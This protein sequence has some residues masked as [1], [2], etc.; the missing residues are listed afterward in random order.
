MKSPAELTTPSYHDLASLASMRGDVRRGEE[1]SLTQVAEQFEALF[2]NMMLDSAR[3][4]VIKGGL[5]DSAALDSR[6]THAGTR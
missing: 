2:V 1:S 5:F 6:Q 4:S 3:Q